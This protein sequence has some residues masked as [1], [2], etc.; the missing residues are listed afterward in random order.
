MRYA[1]H[2]LTL[3]LGEIMDTL[4]HYFNEIWDLLRQGF[5]QINEVL[6]LLVA[7]YFAYRMSA[8]KD[9]WKVA[10]G[11]TLIY[12]VAL[13]L[14]PVIDHNA[15]FRLPPLTDGAYFWN[16]VALFLGFSLAVAA[17]FFVKKNVIKGGGG[18]H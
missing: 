4:T 18:G 9:L 10:L 3:F 6:G 1:E 8:W 17:M 5:G 16:L 13:I 14:V 12:A 7:L 15:A 2:P 11:A